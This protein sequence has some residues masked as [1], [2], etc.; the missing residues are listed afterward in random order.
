[1]IILDSE[2][3]LNQL[4]KLPVGQRTDRLLYSLL[5]PWFLGYWSFSQPTEKGVELADVLTWYDDVVFLFEAKTRATGSSDLRWAA[6]RLEES[7]LS[8]NARARLLREGRGECT[9][10]Q[11]VACYHQHAQ[12]WSRFDA[13]H[14]TMVAGPARVPPYPNGGVLCAAAQQVA[15]LTGFRRAPGRTRVRARGGQRIAT[16]PIQQ[17]RLTDSSG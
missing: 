6:R 7:V 13:D 9:A 16:R 8:I 5:E 12:R 4:L 14:A 17:L 15:R 10:G 1:M 11:G 2:R 3:R